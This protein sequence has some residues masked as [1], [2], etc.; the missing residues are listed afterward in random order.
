MTR[1]C[2]RQPDFFSSDD[3]RWNAVVARDRTA[4][5]AFVYAV[6]TTGIYCR[7]GCPARH[8]ARRSVR[9]FPDP[10]AAEAAGFRACK[11]CNP[12]GLDA[13][14]VQRC[15][16]ERACRDIEDAAEIPSL[17]DLAD[18][19]GYSPAY[20]HRVFKQIVGVAPGDYARAVRRLRLRDGMQTRPGRMADIILDAGYGSLAAGYADGRAGLG[21]PLGHFRRHGQGEIIHVGRVETDLGTVAVGMTQAGLCMVVFT[22]GADPMTVARA[23]FSRADLH[24]A[25]DEHDAVL[26]LVAGAVAD[27]ADAAELPVDIRGTAF[28]ARVWAGL[29]AIPPGTTTSYS[30]LAGSLGQPTAARAVATACAANPLAV[31]V[32]CHRV[33]R[34]DGGLAGY[35]WGVER[36]RALL[37]REAGKRQA[38]ED[39]DLGGDRS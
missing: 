6:T 8:P 31:L 17:D 20:F 3:E 27:P 22:D 28:Q 34:G 23:R 24:P 38:P 15:V 11:R 1:A 4:R 39:D 30:A 10:S 18:A 13:A 25:G 36:K 37:A 2:A 16:I 5:K 14:A 32:P 7:C 29:R 9:F 33:V 21:M 26:Q 12:K 19:A 35:R